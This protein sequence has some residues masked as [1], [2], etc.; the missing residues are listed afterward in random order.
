MNEKK[1]S[2]GRIVRYN[3]TEAEQQALG[4]LNCNQSKQLPAI[5][6]ATWGGTTVNVKVFVDGGVQDLWKTS[7]TQGNNPGNWQWPDEADEFAEA[8]KAAAVKE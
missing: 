3:T 8:Q 4:L 7:V 5:I 2:I 6:V 1:I